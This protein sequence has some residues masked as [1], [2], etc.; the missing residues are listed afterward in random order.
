MLV[1]RINQTMLNRCMVL[2]EAKGVIWQYYG[3]SVETNED[4][5]AI[6]LEV[7]MELQ[8]GKN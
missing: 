2:P 7:H 8:G 5:W 6:W 1:I 4:W 3:A